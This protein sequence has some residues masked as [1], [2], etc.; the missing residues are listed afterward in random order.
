[1]PQNERKYDVELKHCITPGC[2][3]ELIETMYDET[4]N[5]VTAAYKCPI[6]GRDFTVKV[7]V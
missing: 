4:L 1:M 6:C 5:W 3:G 7:E 2:A